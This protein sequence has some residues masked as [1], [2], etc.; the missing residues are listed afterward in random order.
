MKDKFALA[1][2]AAILSVSAASAQQVITQPVGVV[3]PGSTCVQGTEEFK[4]WWCGSFQDKPACEWK[5]TVNKVDC[6][7]AVDKCV[8]K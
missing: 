4:N 1:I 8:P 2:L 5:D 7:W 3:C 6:V